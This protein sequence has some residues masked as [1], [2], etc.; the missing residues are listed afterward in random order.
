MT[1]AGKVVASKVFVTGLEEGLLPHR[2]AVEADSV[3][4]G[5]IEEEVRVA[6]V[7]VTRPRERLYLTCCR[8]RRRGE[9]TV[10]R[11]PSRFLR[12]LPLAGA[13]TA[14]VPPAA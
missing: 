9:G 7:A 12:G 10:P 11:R 13:A 3:A 6:Y 5:A 2:R 8:R 1:S 14:P 4:P